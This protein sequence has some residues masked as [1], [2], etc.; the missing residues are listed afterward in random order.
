MPSL[1]EEQHVDSVAATDAEQIVDLV[2]QR[3]DV[4]A[5]VDDADVTRR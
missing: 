3:S 1:D 2:G 4:K 5:A